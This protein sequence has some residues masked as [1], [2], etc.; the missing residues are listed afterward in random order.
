M[1][2][3]EQN[4]R[5]TLSLHTSTSSKTRTHIWIDSYS[6]AMGKCFTDTEQTLL[7]SKEQP[8]SLGRYALRRQ[9]DA[10][11]SGTTW[12]AYDPEAGRDV[13][14]TL[15]P[16]ADNQGG[17]RA[18]LAHHAR[19]WQKVDH[20]NVAKISEV[21]VYLD[22]RTRTRRNEGVFV[23]REQYTGMRLRRWLDAQPPGR[24]SVAKIIETFCTVGL[25]LHA[26]HQ[27]GVVHGDGGLDSVHVGFD[28]VVRVVGFDGL[29][30]HGD[31][32][33]VWGDQYNFCAALAAA[34][35]SR[36]ATVSRRQR[37]VLRRGTATRPADRFE[38]MAALVH[39]LEGTRSWLHALSAALT[40]KVPRAPGPS[41]TAATFRS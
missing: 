2:L 33:D 11:S 41:A 21:G 39:A 28:G 27:A 36:G 24:R 40:K 10:S 29:G 12:V 19:G 17:A 3:G 9:V 4:V 6:P 34:L 38:S 1:Q 15:M 30:P 16:T 26:A 32:P 22:P 7:A 14:V 18:R 31:P 37:E 5:E 20:P 25:A 13:A 23:V 8:V 35:T